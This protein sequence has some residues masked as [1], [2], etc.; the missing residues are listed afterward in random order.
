MVVKR[1]EITFNCE[2]TTA[3]VE[4][5]KEDLDEDMHATLSKS[6]RILLIE[7]V[8]D[9]YK[10]IELLAKNEFIHDIG[11]I[12]EIVD[13]EPEYKDEEMLIQWSPE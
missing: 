9:V 6:Q 13:Y 7:G 2:V 12:R 3:E 11:L 4:W 10:L 5:F 1:F 8:E